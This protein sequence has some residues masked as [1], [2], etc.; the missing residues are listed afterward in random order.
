MVA[1]STAAIC[2]GILVD[3]VNRTISI[4]DEKL[5]EIFDL[6]KQWGTKSTCTKTQLQSFLGSLLYITKC[7]CPAR[8]FFNR[9]LQVQGMAMQLSIYALPMNSIGTSIG[10]T[11]S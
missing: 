6:C 4:P 2:L 9:M 3:S 1:P 7:V 8:F 10:L 11:P 5:K